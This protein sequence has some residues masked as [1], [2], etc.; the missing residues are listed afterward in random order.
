MESKV[1]IKIINPEVITGLPGVK[2][3]DFPITKMEEDG[4]FTHKP[5]YH[6]AVAKQDINQG[7][8]AITLTG[9]WRHEPSRR[10]IQIGEKHLDSAIGGYVNHSCE[11]NCAVLIKI[12]DMTFKEQY[13]PW[14][15]GIKGTLTSMLVSEPTPVLVAVKPIFK[16]QEVTFN[17]NQTEESLAEPF[18]CEC[19]SE[20][21][22]GEIRGW[23]PKWDT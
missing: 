10:T 8:V 2:E 20:N 16:G 6:G 22:Y 4:E 13:V 15:V 23:L 5:L 21:C 12:K 14:R 1:E 9:E 11:P 3:R 17:Y 18:D 19:G 7:Q